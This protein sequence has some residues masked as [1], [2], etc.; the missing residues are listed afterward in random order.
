[1]GIETALL[2]LAAGSAVSSVSGAF[3]A[4]SEAQGNAASAEYNAATARQNALIARRKGELDALNV[5]RSGAEL[6]GYEQSGYAAA[7]VAQTG[8]AADV[9]AMSAA[10][11]ETDALTAKYNSELNA[12]G[13]DRAAGLDDLSAKNARRAGKYAVA[14][15]LLGGTLGVGKI[16]TGT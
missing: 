7:G 16:V 15:A 11:I 2:V 13:Y 3:A 10:R 12:I 8:S 4:G 6:L 9:R 1:M 5:R 14:S